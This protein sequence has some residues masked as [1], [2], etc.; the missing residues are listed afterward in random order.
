MKRRSRLRTAIH[1]A[2][3]PRAFRR[4]LLAYRSGYR[5]P[6]HPAR[7]TREGVQSV[8][9]AHGV[10]VNPDMRTL[11]ILNRP[12]YTTGGLLDAWGAA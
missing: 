5:M 6:R 9:P 4:G 2:D 10:S 1:I 11:A 7:W 3:F 8:K 12:G